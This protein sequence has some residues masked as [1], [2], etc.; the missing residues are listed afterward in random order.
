LRPENLLHGKVCRP[1]SFGA[2]LVSADLAAAKAM[3]GVVVVRD[4]NFVAVAAP[5]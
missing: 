5:T 3:P 1:V 2:A 4:E